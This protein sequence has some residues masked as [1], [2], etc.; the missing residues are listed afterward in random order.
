LHHQKFIA[1]SFKAG[2][3]HEAPDAGYGGG[4]GPSTLAAEISKVR[5]PDLDL[6]H[7]YLQPVANSLPAAAG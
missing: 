7:A 1:F 5:Y 4:L 6:S 2:E 3:S